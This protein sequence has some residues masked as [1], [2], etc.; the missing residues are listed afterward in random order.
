[1][2]RVWVMRHGESETNRDGLWGGQLDAPLTERGIAQA[3]EAGKRLVGLHFDKIYA[4]D[5]SRARATAENAIPGCRYETLCA[6]REMDVGD[7]AGTPYADLSE[8]ARQAVIRDGYGVYGGETKEAFRTRID[9]FMRKLES[10]DLQ[11]VAVFTHAGC[12]RQFFELATGA[13]FVRG[14]ILCGNCAT[15][16]YEYENGVWRLH[17]WYNLL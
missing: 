9:S 1:M 17:S 13:T 6:L 11:S 16:V 4:S 8:E 15:A 3:I 14:G 2:M 10:E 12:M 5:L 7:L